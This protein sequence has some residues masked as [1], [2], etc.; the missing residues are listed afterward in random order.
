MQVRAPSRPATNQI[1]LSRSPIKRR[2]N[3][4]PSLVDFRESAF[5]RLTQQ[6]Q[7][8]NSTAC[9]PCRQAVRSRSCAHLASMQGNQTA[10]TTSRTCIADT[11]PPANFI[12]L[13]LWSVGWQCLQCR[14]KGPI[15]SNRCLAKAFQAQARSVFTAS[16]VVPSTGLVITFS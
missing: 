3:L 13:S 7:A 10:C 16:N 2:Y 5:H 8:E 9:E 14:G 11:V 1:Q 4:H 6:Q 12:M 15:L